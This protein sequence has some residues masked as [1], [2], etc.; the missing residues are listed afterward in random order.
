VP[1]KNRSI[2]ARNGQRSQDVDVIKHGSTASMCDKWARDL[3][4]RGL[5][6]RAILD[7]RK[8]AS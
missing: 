5:A 4:D 1:R 8:E 6:T 7:P 2:R 3:V